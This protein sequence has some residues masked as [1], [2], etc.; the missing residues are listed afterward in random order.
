MGGLWNASGVQPSRTL[1][2]PEF[3]GDRAEL[4][5][6]LSPQ[7]QSRV[8][9]NRPLPERGA[10][11]CTAYERMPGARRVIDLE[12]PDRHQTVTGPMGIKMTE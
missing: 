12:A 9:A 6:L 10:K 5:S 2:G 8:S 11:L 7:L 4:R 3:A 1:S